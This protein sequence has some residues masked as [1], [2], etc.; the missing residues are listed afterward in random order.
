MSFKRIILF[1]FL[2]QASVSAVFA[3]KAVK[4]LNKIITPEMVYKDMMY[5]A[6]DEL[7][8][9][10]TGERGNELAAEYIAKEFKSAGVKTVPGMKDYFQQVPFIKFN[11]IDKGSI[12]FENHDYKNKADMLVM[13]GSPIPG[14]SEEA[15]YI[16]F[17]MDEDYSG[18]D[19]KGKYALAQSGLPNGGGPQEIFAAMS[20]K[21]KWAKEH[22][23]I[24]LIEIYSLNIP[25]NL[26]K[27]YFSKE[28]LE[29]A[30][31]P[32]NEVG[33]FH[34][35]L[36]FPSGQSKPNFEIGKAYPLTAESPSIVNKPVNAVN[37]IG[38]IPGK[39]KMLR[40]QYVLLTAHFDH[41]GVNA[42]HP[43]GND[44]IWNGA[45]DN[46]WGVVSLLASA[47]YY[48]K[49]PPARSILIAAVNGEEI[50]LLG[51]KYLAD[52]PVIPWNKVIFDLNSD[53]AGYS[54]TTIVSII[55]LNRVG[56]AEEMNEACKIFDLNTFADP[57]PEQG[58]FDR[59]DNVNFAKLGIPAPTFSAGFKTF[60]AEIGKYYHQAIDNPDNISYGYL[61][62]FTKAF[63][64]AGYL[65][66]NM[67]NAPRWI[68]GDKYEGAGKGLY[69]Y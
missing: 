67:K 14:K 36:Q 54:D 39:D 9:R 48:A 61:H 51:S 7:K 56:T 2:I 68:S 52:H 45:R 16:N 30:D 55:G 11:A 64:Y 32:V 66:A 34:A 33:I 5:L 57:A 46:A 20:E 62:R 17:G 21:K 23:A 63:V 44:T 28:R 38:M 15:V 27:N 37:V 12:H 19:V 10:K 40:D 60:D 65:I 50:G 49:Y 13:D 59:S 24:G 35:Y 6:S 47:R 69:G 43:V 1:V 53:G 4:K 26:F 3:Q 41:I 18:V 25:W 42:G 29:L 31:G 8:G 58:L 22:G